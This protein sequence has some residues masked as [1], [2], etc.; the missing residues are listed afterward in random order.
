MGN[1]LVNEI[2]VHVESVELEIEQQLNIGDEEEELFF[3]L[4]MLD[5]ENEINDLD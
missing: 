2:V 5:F 3:N 1:M 4:K